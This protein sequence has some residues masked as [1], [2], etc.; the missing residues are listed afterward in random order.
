MGDITKPSS[1]EN[2]NRKELGRKPS[3]VAR[4]STKI[5]PFTKPMSFQNTNPF[6]F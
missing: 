1:N 6:T 5:N 2:T 3:V 4:L